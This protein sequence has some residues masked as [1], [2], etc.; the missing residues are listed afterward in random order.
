[1][2][3]VIEKSKFG[4]IKDNRH[5]FTQKAWQN[6]WTKMPQFSN[7]KQEAYATIVFRFSNEH[8]LQVFANL[9][10][11]ELNKDVKKAWYPK[12]NR[13]SPAWER[14]IHEQSDNKTESQS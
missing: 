7:E 6:E 14:Y 13:D 2:S 5:K 8:D 12:L 3:D 11:Q 1:M 10:G 9:I 4:E